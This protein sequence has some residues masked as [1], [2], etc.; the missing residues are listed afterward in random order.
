MRNLQHNKTLLT[1]IKQAAFTLLTF[2]SLNAIAQDSRTFK[3]HVGLIY[4]LSTN[5]TSAALDTNDLSIHLIAGVSSVERGSAFAGFSNIVRNETRGALFAGFANHVGKQVSGGLFAGFLNTSQSANGL[6]FSGF[7]NLSKGNVTGAQL[8]GFLNTTSFDMEGLQVAGFA[9]IVRNINGTQLAGFSNIAQNISASQF[10]GFI[11][12]AKDVKGSQFA[13]FINVAKKVK[14]AQIAGFINVAESSDCPIGII[15]IIKNG[16][17]SIATTIDE[18]QTTMFT[19]RSGGKY[20]YGI[21]GVGYNWKNVDEVY[22]FEA[23]FG[24]HFYQSKHFRLN[25]ELTQAA[26]EDFK[27]GEYCKS[28]LRLLPAVKIAPWLEFFG[29]PSINFVSTNTAEGLALHPA[30]DG[31]VLHTWQNRSS[32]YRQSLHIGYHGGLQIVF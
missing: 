15:N 6:Q 19:F 5:G 7:A 1:G 4:P 24:A 11:N 21:V 20:L 25:V 2:V 29:G 31:L 9:N 8:A 17:K 27:D 14:G 18:T 12:I 26:L 32:D 28:T 10:A 23:G 30:N 3:T 16:E 22:A 13:G